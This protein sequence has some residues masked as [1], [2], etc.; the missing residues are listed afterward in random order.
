MAPRDWVAVALTWWLTI[1]G[2]ILV[3]VG[4]AADYDLSWWVSLGVGCWLLAGV[5][6]WLTLGDR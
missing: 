6:H 1:V 4:V 2:T 3:A 5:Y